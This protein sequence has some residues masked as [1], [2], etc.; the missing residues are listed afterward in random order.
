MSTRELILSEVE[1]AREEDLEALYEV[2]R[3][4]KSERGQA[5]PRPGALARLKTIRI[6][7]PEDFSSNLDAYVNGEKP[8]ASRAD[9]D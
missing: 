8:L 9:A 6:E 7:A 1:N 3:R 4:F 5:P 2:V